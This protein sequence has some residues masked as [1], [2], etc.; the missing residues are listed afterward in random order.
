V[1]LALETAANRVARDRLQQMERIGLVGR[2]AEQAIL[3]MGPP[4]DRLFATIGRLRTEHD[5][6][7]GREG[8]SWQASC[9][10]GAELTRA[11]ATA[12]RFW[13]S[14]RASRR[15]SISFSAPVFHGVAPGPRKP[16]AAFDPTRGHEP[17]ATDRVRA[18]VPALG[19]RGAGGALERS[20]PAIPGGSSALVPHRERRAY[21]RV[22]DN[23]A[24]VKTA[25]DGG[26][27]LLTLERNGMRWPFPSS[28]TWSST[29]GPVDD[30]R[31]PAGNELTM[32]LR[33][34]TQS[35]QPT[36]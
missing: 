22:A 28:T 23:I 12:T 4:L 35:V 36:S 8:G 6:S 3:E 29:S 7:D 18:D 19:P 5:L 26:L 31:H 27:R 33:R 1:A 13:V 16:R 11:G 2:L 20:S 10:M 17:A 15:P 32:V 14:W 25:R 9:G 30:R 24:A 34:S 21:I